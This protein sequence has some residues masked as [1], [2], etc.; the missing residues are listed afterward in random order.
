MKLSIIIPVYNVER[1][2]NRCLMSVINQPILSNNYE[3]IIVNDG[4]TDDSLSIINETIIGQDN[5]IVVSQENGGPGAARN[6]GLS[7]AKGEYI[8][9]VDSDDWITENC[10]NIIIPL[11]N[12]DIDCLTF[13]CNRYI[14][15][16]NN[17]IESIPFEGIKSGIDLTKMHKVSIQSPY[18]I[19]KRT[20]FFDNNLFFDKDIYYED[21][22][23]TPK[24]YYYAR[25]CMFLDEVCYSYFQREG[26]IMSSFSLKKAL[27]ILHVNENLLN[28]AQKAIKNKSEQSVFYY[29]IGLTI[30]VLLFKLNQLT[31]TEYQQI[32]SMLIEKRPLFRAMFRSRKLKYKVEGMLFLCVPRCTLKLYSFFYSNKK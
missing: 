19:F 32:T 26:S 12:Q 5:I 18:S 11:L 17:Q 15:S 24:L 27:D 31:L 21:S 30:N 4:S 1:Y 23:L 10:L 9:F 3:V 16:V 29:W 28:F 6:K 2:V 14:D 20:I 25:K 13:K 8:W 7:L 22:E